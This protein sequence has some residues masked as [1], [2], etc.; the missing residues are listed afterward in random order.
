MDQGYIKLYRTIEDNPIVCKDNDH[1]RVWHY[2]LYNAT[3]KS[4]EV[5]FGKEKI[6]L[7]PGELIIGEEKVADKCKVSRDKAR[8]ILKAFENAQQI[9]QRKC[10]KGTLITLK[11]WE[12]YQNSTQQNA[13]PVHNECTTNAQRVHTNKNERMKECNNYMCVQRAYEEN[14][15]CH[16]GSKFKSESCFKC[17]RKNQCPNETSPEFIILYGKEFKEYD[18]ERTEKL[19]QIANEM[20][21]RGDPVEELFDYDWLNDLEEKEREENYENRRY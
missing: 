20:K 8:R 5:I 19:K 15:F 16:L 21:S 7:K 4:R 14:D 1:F 11:N 17:L 12:V 10:S 3:H 6:I 9:A 2:L 18:I 13:Q